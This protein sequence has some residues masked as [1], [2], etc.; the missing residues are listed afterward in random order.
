M[1]TAT[2][3]SIVLIVVMVLIVAGLGWAFRTRSP[4]AIDAILMVLALGAV[5]LQVSTLASDSKHK[6]S[7]R[8][9]FSS[10]S[11]AFALPPSS[12]SSAAAAAAAASRPVTAAAT[13]AAAAEGPLPADVLSALTMYTS[14][15]DPRSY[16]T[17]R[18]GKTWRNVA[19]FAPATAGSAT[20][21]G[22]K[23]SNLYFATVPAFTRGDGFVLGANKITGPF[24]HQL[25]IDGDR[26]YTVFFVSQLT[27]EVLPPN[28][29]TVQVFKIFA[30]TPG[31][32][33]LS[34][35]LTNGGRAGDR[36]KMDVVLHVGDVKPA[37][38]QGV[39]VDPRHKQLWI[40][41]KAQTRFRVSIVDLGAP[42]YERASLID[43]TISA[44]LMKS[45]VFSN[46]DMTV[47]GGGV[48]NATLTAF[49]MLSKAM[50]DSNTVAL[51]THYKR[52]LQR[53]DPQ[54]VAMQAKIA[55]AANLRKCPYNSKTCAQCGGV[56]DWTNMTEVMAGGTTC[57]RAIDAF[58][59][60]NPQHER[61]SCWSA[62]NP[63]YNTTCRAYRSVFN[64]AELPLA[65]SP[66]G[67]GRAADDA[68]K[69]CKAQM[70]D[71]AVSKIVRALQKQHLASG[72][73]ARRGGAGGG[74]DDKE[75]MCPADG[76]DAEDDDAADED[77]HHRLPALP[78]PILPPRRRH[79]HHRHGNRGSKD[80][81]DGDS[82]SDS[83]RDSDSDRRKHV[84]R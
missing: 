73:V 72:A 29:G 36:I 31:N 60:A 45:V 11:S 83:D 75:G 18:G 40:V 12:S 67:A 15:L 44:D 21:D 27:G 5:T 41:T 56:R 79:H 49:G 78:P 84:R 63:D 34:L 35:L 22:D 23:D 10:S 6:L 47:N 77:T 81:K 26:S 68:S 30:N 58:C 38:A 46:V 64:G 51:Y 82:S 13:A 14:S 32:N 33:G 17:K 48:W 55:E 53:F 54:Y 57:L 74:G 28:R 2:A 71:E 43:T 80:R 4:R 25:G 7:S 70:D 52:E 50:D 65:P 42:Q 66:R 62:N 24:S 61:C 3:V 16:D 8:E 1:A 39:I 76:R 37:I 19:P 69:V 59:S 20:C 9:A